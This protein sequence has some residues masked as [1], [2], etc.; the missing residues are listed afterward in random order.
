MLINKANIKKTAII[1]SLLLVISFI[2][3]AVSNSQLIAEN[4]VPAE[5]EINDNTGIEATGIVAVVNGTAA[6]YYLITYI[7]KDIWRQFKI[8]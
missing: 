5:G 8:D 3:L 7:F 6:F 1:L 4:N 2:V